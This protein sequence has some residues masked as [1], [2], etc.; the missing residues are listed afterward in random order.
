ME[1]G[2]HLISARIG[3][4][5]HGIYIGRNKVIHYSGSSLGKNE[6]GVIE[7]VDLETFCQ[8]N[9]YTIQ[10]YP[11]RAFSREQSI[12]R[13]KSRLGEDWYNVLL[14]NCEHFVTWCIQGIHDSQQTSRLIDAT[15]LIVIPSGLILAKWLT[16][17][18][19]LRN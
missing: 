16:L 3:Y 7:I 10:T 5:H 13:A 9:G 15:T 4:S 12:E 6:K 1:K 2:D 18:H 8:G 11:F 19:E 14:N 17:R